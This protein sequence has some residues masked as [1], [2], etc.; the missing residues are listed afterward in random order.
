M[1]QFDL[2][3]RVAERRHH[4]R[5]APRSRMSPIRPL[6]ARRPGG[7]PTGR[8]AHRPPSRAADADG[9]APVRQNGAAGTVDARGATETVEAGV[10]SGAGTVAEVGTPEPAPRRRALSPLNPPLVALATTVLFLLG[11]LAYVVM[12]SDA[13]APPADDRPQL[14]E[15]APIALHGD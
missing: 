4:P 5:R 2:L 6:L 15:V 13:S 8:A 10:S 9:A 7:S 11:L 12:S 14:T 3:V 1:A